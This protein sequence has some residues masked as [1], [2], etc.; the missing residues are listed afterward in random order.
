M[1]KNVGEILHMARKN[2]V[3][4]NTQWMCALRGDRDD[5]LSKD[6]KESIRKWA[7]KF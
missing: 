5:K 7:N 1:E 4:S 2:D 6:K 3:Y